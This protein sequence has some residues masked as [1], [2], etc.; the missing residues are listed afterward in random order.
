[1][2]CPKHILHVL[3]FGPNIIKTIVSLLASSVNMYED[4]LV[5]M[6]QAGL[7]DVCPVCKVHLMGQIHRVG[8]MS[9]THMSFLLSVI[10]LT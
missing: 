5:L 9:A 10:A 6:V 3:F 7:Y 8:N 1:M 4:V 2:D